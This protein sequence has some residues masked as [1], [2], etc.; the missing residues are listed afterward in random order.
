[1]DSFLASE[2]PGATGAEVDLKIFVHPS[3]TSAILV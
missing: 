1:M 3:D 2:Q